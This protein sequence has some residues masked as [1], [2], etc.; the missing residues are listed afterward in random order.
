ML[1]GKVDPPFGFT[2][3]PGIV[4]IL[5]GGEEG[6]AAH[7]IG[8]LAPVLYHR[9]GAQGPQLLLGAVMDCGQVIQDDIDCPGVV[10]GSKERGVVI[11]GIGGQDDP[12]AIGKDMAGIVDEAG[13]SISAGLASKDAFIFPETL[14]AGQNHFGGAVIVNGSQCILL[15]RGKR[16]LEMEKPGSLSCAGHDHIICG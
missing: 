11:N 15:T 5:V 13:R 4:H 10:H 7:G 8:V 16:W 9:V 12:C 1:A 6:E 14:R 2:E 3:F